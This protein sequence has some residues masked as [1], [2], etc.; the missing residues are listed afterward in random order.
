M[1]VKVLVCVWVHESDGATRRRS[2]CEQLVGECYVSGCSGH[3]VDE[4][5]AGRRAGRAAALRRAS[6]ERPAT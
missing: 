2:I 1:R 4:A 6:G 3:V 5:A